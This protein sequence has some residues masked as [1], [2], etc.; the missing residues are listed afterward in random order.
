MARLFCA[1]SFSLALQLSVVAQTPDTASLEGEI[2]D[3]SQAAVAGVHVTLTNDRIGVERST[4]SDRFGRFSFAGLPVAG[5]YRIQ[6]EKA[7]FAGADLS[8]LTLAAGVGA[9]VKLLLNVSAEHTQ[10]TVTGT[11]GEVR[12]DQPQIGDRLSAKQIGETPLLNRRITYLPLLNA[13]NRPA[14]NQGDVF[15][16]QNL[17]TTNG[18]GRRQTT[19]E[20]DGAT[21]NDSWGRQTIF[22]NIPLAAVEEMG[23]L[24]NAFSAEYGGSTGSA[25]NLVTRSG[26]SDFHGEIL[27]LSRPSGTSARLSGFNATNAGSGNDLTSDMLAQGAL[28]LSGPIGRGKRTQFFAAG[29]F[30]AENRGS[31][32]VSPDCAGQLRGALSELVRYRAS[33]PS[34]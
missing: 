20:I 24:V 27:G 14:I 1:L 3:T 19:F 2:V 8:N 16:N 13:A 7:H 26:T 25:V 33:G 22:T 11:A 12:A 17:F 29:E 5:S 18:A 34:I 31:P 4:E 9:R 32:V 10:V 15:M 23:V 6:A 30:S 21:G 28:S